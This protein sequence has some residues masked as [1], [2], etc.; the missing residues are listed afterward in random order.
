MNTSIVS[1]NTK[2]NSRA[3]TLI[4]LLVT[5]GIIAILASMLLPA[6]GGA[7]RRA[8]KVSCLNNL[9][10]IGLAVQMYT[11]DND[12]RL[13]KIEP[14][15]SDPLYVN[16]A[17]PTINEVLGKL[18]GNTNNAVFR[19]PE[20]QA[21]EPRWKKE[22]SSYMWNSEYNN[23]KIDRINLRGFVNVPAQ[24]APLVFDYENFHPGQTKG[25][26]NNIVV[27]SRNALFVDGHVDK[28]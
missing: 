4:E 7:K 27:G 6:L 12:G 15:P 25:E 16:P 10:Q 5:I 11:D 28:L 24:K 19:C 17:L 2:H 1:S 14:L 9:R 18:L 3:F 26:S 22:F 21:A 20:D 13:P 23:R 8:Q